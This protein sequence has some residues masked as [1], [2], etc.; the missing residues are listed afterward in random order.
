MPSTVRSDVT[1]GIEHNAIAGPIGRLHGKGRV[2]GKDMTFE[3][4]RYTSK[5]AIFDVWIGTDPDSFPSA[6]DT[7]F[8]KS[9]TLD[10]Q[11]VP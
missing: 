10:G 11:V 1:T 2:G 7:A 8:L 4:R 9:I 5:T 6:T 3:I